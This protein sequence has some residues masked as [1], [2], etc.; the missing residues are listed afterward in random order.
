[1]MAPDQGAAASAPAAPPVR[2]ALY[3]SCTTNWSAK[4]TQ[5]SV[6]C[7]GATISFYMVR[8]GPTRYGMIRHDPTLHDDLRRLATTPNYPRQGAGD[9][10][11]ACD[12]LR[13]MHARAIAQKACAGGSRPA[14]LAS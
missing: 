8:R 13:C 6:L 14:E 7:A 11:A 3:T 1:M 9:G 4:Q 2:P 12:P 5:L 10:A